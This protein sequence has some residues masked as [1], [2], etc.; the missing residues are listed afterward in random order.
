[1]TSN[2]IFLRVAGILVLVTLIYV[3]GPALHKKVSTPAA[4]VDTT[5]FVECGR[6]EEVACKNPEQTLTWQ[7]ARPNGFT[8]QCTCYRPKK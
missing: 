7:P 6:T 1:M 8:Y 4:C 3:F 2:G 5:G